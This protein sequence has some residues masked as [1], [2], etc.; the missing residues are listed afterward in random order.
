LSIK[1]I[2]VVTPQEKVQ[3]YINIIGS[4]PQCD[5]DEIVDLL[6]CEA[7]GTED[8]E[9]LIAFVPMAFAHEILAPLGVGLP[10]AFLVKDWDTGASARGRLN[11][12]PIFVAAKAMAGEMLATSQ[13]KQRALD[14]AALSAEMSVARELG[15]DGSME[16]I[17]LTE[18]VLARLP[19]EHIK[20]QA[21][22]FRWR[23]WT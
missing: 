5:I 3:R 18:T 14:I 7:I 19:I 6:A 2:R 21:I 1:E 16:G 20:R 23:F 15:Q 8:G 22:G 17:V 13:T 10:S 11:E 4:H 9:C 12:E